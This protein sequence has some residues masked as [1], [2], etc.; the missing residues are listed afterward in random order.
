L[1]D[2]LNDVFHI[3][4]IEEKVA[5]VDFRIYNRSKTLIYYSDDSYI[6]WDGMYKD[7]LSNTGSYFW[8]LTYLLKSGK[9]KYAEGT[10]IL[11]E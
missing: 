11:L 7:Q 6:T 3:H 9:E 5:S 1:R 8:Q 4:I 10:V 2:G